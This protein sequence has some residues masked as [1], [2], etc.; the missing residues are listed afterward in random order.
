MYEQEVEA[1]VIV[2]VWVV[3]ELLIESALCLCLLLTI[4]EVSFHSA[5]IKVDEMEINKYLILSVTPINQECDLQQ[6]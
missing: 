4:E 1:V 6:L 5:F 3:S 2:F